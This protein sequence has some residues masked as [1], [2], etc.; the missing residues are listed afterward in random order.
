[1]A[2]LKLVLDGLTEAIA[3]DETVAAASFDAHAT[4]R[5]FVTVRGPRHRSGT[6]RSSTPST[7]TA[8]SSTS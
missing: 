4:S 8:R 3:A 2:T 6:P 5:L 7:S 1:M